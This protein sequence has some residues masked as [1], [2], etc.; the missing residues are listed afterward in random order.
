VTRS[1]LATISRRPRVRG[2][3]LLSA[4]ALMAVLLIIFLAVLSYCLSRYGQH[5]KA[6][7]RLT[8]GFLA[9]AGVQTLLARLANDSLATPDTTETAP[10]GGT[11]RVKCLAWGPYLLVISEGQFANQHV[12]SSALLGSV[13]PPCFRGAI[14]VT[15]PNY[16]LVA[17]GNTIITGDVFTGLLGMTTGRIRGEGIVNENFHNGQVESA[18]TPPSVSLDT[19]IFARYLVEQTKRRSATTTQLSGTQV[20][21]SPPPEIAK[22]DY[23]CRIENNLRLESCKLEVGPH[24]LSIFVGGSVE[25]TGRTTI[26]GL[27]EIVAGGPVTISDSSVV[28]ESL[29]YSSD[30]I[31]VAGKSQFSGVAVSTRRICVSERAGMTYPGLLMVKPIQR[32]SSDSSGIWIQSHGSLE[33]I[34]YLAATT[35]PKRSPVY[36]LYQDTG[37]VFSGFLVSEN[38]SD[39]RGTLYGSVMTRQFLYTEPATEYVNWVKDLKVDRARLKVEPVLPLLS[40]SPLDLPRSIVRQETEK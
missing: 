1:G 34:C 35:S 8:A 15:D 14:T 28:D 19:T 18:P 37:T 32:E 31:L 12:R 33:G 39:V 13:P 27:V 29:L 16:P 38:V 23:S 9:D 7:N 17:A 30:S 40:R 20:W 24:M 2:T 11:I 5:I 21:S 3:V 22:G 4:L 10:N 36:Q 26:T 25:I 6:N